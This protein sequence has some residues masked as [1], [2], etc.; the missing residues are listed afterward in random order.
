M[1]SLAKES[2]TLSGVFVIIF[3]ATIWVWG[4]TAQG[5]SLD[6]TQTA[7]TD[8]GVCDADCSLREAIADANTGDTITIPIGTYTLTQGTE[9]V[10]DVD[11]TLTGAGPGDTII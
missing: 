6:V 7:D 8:D 10:I 2:V 9:L 4:G 1:P 11:L 3:L 5:A